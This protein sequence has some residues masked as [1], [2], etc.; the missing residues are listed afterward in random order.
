MSEPLRLIALDEED[1]AVISA[2]LQDAVV[3]VKDMAF[4]PQTKRFALLAARFDWLSVD[5]G[6][7]E[8]CATGL[9]F[10]RVFKAAVKGFDQADGDRCLNLLSIRFFPEDAPAGQVILTFSGG[11]AIQLDVECLEAQMHDLGPRWPAKAQPGHCL[12]EPAM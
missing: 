3:K 11:A 10:E 9:H 4:L 7:K 5:S 12:D 8:R 6:K 1:L 2:H